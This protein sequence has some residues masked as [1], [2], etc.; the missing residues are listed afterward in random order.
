MYQISSLYIFWFDLQTLSRGYIA[1]ILPKKLKIAIS[2][3]YLQISKNKK[4]ITRSVHLRIPHAK[5]QHPRPKTVAYR[6]RT[7]SHTDRQTDRQTEKANTED[8]FFQ[9]FLFRF[10]FLF[11]LWFLTYIILTF[12][13]ACQA[14]ELC[15]L[16]VKCFRPSCGTWS[17]LR[18]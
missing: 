10:E 13:D 6:P 16:T 12:K 7:D 1:K 15:L 5:N 11:C 9:F 2:R 3:S 18:H 8:P 14:V 4:K 17:Q